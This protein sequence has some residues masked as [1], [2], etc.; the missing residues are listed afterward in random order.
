MSCNVAEH[1]IT[2]GERRE[3]HHLG[4]AG[5]LEIDEIVSQLLR[6][7]HHA[8]RCHEVGVTKRSSSGSTQQL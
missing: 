7:S 5:T 3:Q 1:L 2:S 6:C 4:Q 8:R